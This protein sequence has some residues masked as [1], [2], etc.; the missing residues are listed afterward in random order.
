VK[1]LS[2]NPLFF[3]FFPVALIDGSITLLSQSQAY[4]SGGSVNEASPAYYFLLASPWLY[5]L[6]ALVWFVFWYWAFTKLKEPV[7]LWLA[8]FFLVA[9]SWGSSSWILRYLRDP[10]GYNV[11]NQ[12]QVME[13][14]LVLIIYFALVTL[15]AT[16]WFRKYLKR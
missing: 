14:W 10:S 8:L 2:K 7:N 9:H 5:L 13:V 16:F 15:N 6:G 1:L 12:V 3:V 4:W 11:H